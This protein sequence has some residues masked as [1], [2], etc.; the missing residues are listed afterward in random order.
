MSKI[1]F[2]G[3]KV[4]NDE[5]PKP[6]Q[7]SMS[8]TGLST[9]SKGLLEHD[10]KLNDMDSIVKHTQEIIKKYEEEV[11]QLQKNGDLQEQLINRQ[12]IELEVTKKEIL[13]ARN[14]I[15][16]CVADIKSIWDS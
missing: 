14:E 9:L 7:R 12:I 13:I 1:R 8:T 4:M 16:K 10:E 15:V 3:V 11:K 5:P 2:G 6:M